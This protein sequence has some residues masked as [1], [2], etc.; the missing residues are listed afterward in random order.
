[1]VAR[2]GAKARRSGLDID[3]HEATAQALPF[4]DASFDV[5]LCTLVL[6][7]LPH[8]GIHE[9]AAEMRRVLAPGGRLLVADI[10][11]AHPG[12]QRRTPHSHGSFDGSRIG[13][14]LERTGLDVVESGEVPFRLR[15]FERLLYVG[16]T[17]AERRLHLT[18]VLSTVPGDDGA[19]AWDRPGPGTALDKF[20]LTLAE[21]LAPPIP[22]A[23]GPATAPVF[24]PL[25]RLPAEWTTPEP[26][27][28]LP[29]A[30]TP[31][32]VEAPPPFDWAREAARH[33]GTVVHRVLAQIADEGLAVWTAGRCAALAPRLRA[34]LAAAG[35]DE[36]ELAGSVTSVIDSVSALLGD[37]RG[38]WLFDPAHAEAASEWA[39]GGWNGNA[40][41]HVVVDR[42][43]VA[44]GV[45]WIV[46]FK[47]GTHEGSDREGFLDREQERY[48]GQ[49]E[50]YAAFVRALDPRPIRLALYHPLL[51]GWR[52]WAHDG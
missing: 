44:D 6:H 15:R 51:R 30:V 7:Q 33:V 20:W 49:L 17:R 37:P 35:V 29:V 45:R 36:G 52:E 12:N 28:G 31:I 22:A 25:R 41:T 48:R 21:A 40:V 43:F 19:P 5:V 47:T 13:P 8:E 24:R 1:M 9:A 11:S 16:A 26:M 39:L 34:E 3:F 18:A 46:D 32:E 42:T 23:S 10:D 2:A 14:L 38:R 50:Q 4:A 27:A